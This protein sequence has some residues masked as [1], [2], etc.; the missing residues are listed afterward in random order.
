M[1]IVIST[2]NGSVAQHFGRCPNFSIIEIE[3]GSVKSK[4]V[5]DNPGHAPGLLPKLFNEMGC[6]L[7]IAGG[8]GGRAQELFVQFKMDWIV[9]V[10]GEI[11]QVVNDYLADSLEI[12]GSSCDHGEGHGDGTHGHGNCS[13]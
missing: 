13:H 4:E 5:I 12:G 9:G 1:K 2:E 6:N 7:I 8:M 10:Q 11:D 3:E